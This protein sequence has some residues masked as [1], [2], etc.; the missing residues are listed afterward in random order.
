MNFGQ[1]LELLKQGKTV[2]RR[3]WAEKSP[4]GFVAMHQKYISK[5]FHAEQ[6]DLFAEDWYVLEDSE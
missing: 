6:E 1:A 4:P 2:T 5:T 3:A